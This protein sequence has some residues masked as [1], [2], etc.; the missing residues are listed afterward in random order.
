MH[1]L[2]SPCP[3]QLE[4]SYP[5]GRTCLHRFDGGKRCTLTHFP[6]EGFLHQL[7]GIPDVAEEIS[8]SQD[9]VSVDGVM[10]VRYQGCWQRVHTVWQAPWGHA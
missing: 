2:S 6:I 3:L 8:R 5:L 10:R 1:M 7:L 4:R 9:H